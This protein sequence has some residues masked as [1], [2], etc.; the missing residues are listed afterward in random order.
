MLVQAYIILI[1]ECSIL[2]I[3]M[4]LVASGIYLIE[5]DIQPVK[6]GSIPAAI[7]WTI[8]ALTTVGYGDVT[9]ITPWGKFFGGTITLLAMGMVALPAGILTSS[10]S[11]QAHQK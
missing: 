4:V 6:F 3:M 9:P 1:A 7:W 5:K 11:E 2:L 10:F 8:N